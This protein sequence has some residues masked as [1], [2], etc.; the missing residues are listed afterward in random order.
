MTR[1][2]LG[3]EVCH[4]GGDDDAL[5]KTRGHEG[6]QLLLLSKTRQWVQPFS[7]FLANNKHRQKDVS[8]GHYAPDCA[9]ASTTIF[10]SESNYNERAKIANYVIF[11]ARASG[12][13]RKEYEKLL[14]R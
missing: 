2:Y 14:E 13:R 12:T 1:G 3:T 9:Q 4:S 8:V 6:N 7:I 10:R 5:S 11:N